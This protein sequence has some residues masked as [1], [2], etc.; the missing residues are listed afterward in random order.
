MNGRIVIWNQLLGI[1]MENNC[2]KV[3]KR[4]FKLADFFNQLMDRRSKI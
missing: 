2:V 1:F 3:H 4:L